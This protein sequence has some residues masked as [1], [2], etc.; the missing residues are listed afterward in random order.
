MNERKI[1]VLLVDDSVV[2]RRLL[3]QMLSA[4]PALEVV[5]VAAN[6]KIALNK[7]PQLKPDVVILDVEMPEMN[8]LETL[9]AL[10]KSDKRLPV[11]MFSTLTVR[12]ASATLDALALGANDYVTKPASEGESNSI[13]RTHQELLDKIKVF[14]GRVSLVAR[15]TSAA[16]ALSCVRPTRQYRPAEVIAI[17]I[18]TGG[19]NALA[20]LMPCF[21]ADLAVPI[22]IVQHM[23]PV[24]TKLLAER[25]DAKSNIEI[26]EAAAGD[27]VKPGTAWLARGDYHMTVERVGTE[28]KLRTNQ[29]PQENSCRPA[30]DVLFRSVAAAYG[31]TTLAAVMTGMGQD[32]LKGCEQIRSRGGQI[33]VQDEASSVVWGMPGFVARAGLADSIVPLAELGAEIMRRVRKQPAPALSATIQTGRL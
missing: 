33:V 5:G 25:L 1:R 12:G 2:V 8:G 4:D 26:R 23:P 24:F 14:G 17:G 10:R 21:P 3:T 31:P 27:V 29:A 7:I 22:L 11:I 6:G 13:S 9:A 18:S 16:P 15:E 32:G 19:P 28:V 20:E 30:A